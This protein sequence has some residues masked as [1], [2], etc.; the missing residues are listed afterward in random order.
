MDEIA[1]LPEGTRFLVL[2]P[3][4]KEREGEH[5]EVIAGARKTGFTR[6]RVDGVVVSLDAVVD[7]LIAKA[8]IRRRLS[9]FCLSSW[10]SLGQSVSSARST[11]PRVPEPASPEAQRRSAAS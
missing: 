3:L 8:G 6:V 1:Q 9:G 11:Q 10:R 2:A 4:V 7:R 5:R